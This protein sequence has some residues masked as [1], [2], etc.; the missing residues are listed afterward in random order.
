MEKFREILVLDEFDIPNSNSITLTKFI[1]IINQHTS[2]VGKTSDEIL[3]T[4][5]TSDAY[6]DEP[7]WA[8]IK[9]W[10]EK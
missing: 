6:Y 7:V 3:V 2:N 10:C 8:E 4:L 1:S 5:G 9:F